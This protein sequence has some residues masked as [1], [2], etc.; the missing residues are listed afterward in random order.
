M[1]DDA[2][3]LNAMATPAGQRAARVETQA[4]GPFLLVA[5]EMKGLDE[6]HE[7]GEMARHAIEFQEILNSRIIYYAKETQ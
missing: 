6:S 4:A 5:H 1:A 7:A 3:S 2:L